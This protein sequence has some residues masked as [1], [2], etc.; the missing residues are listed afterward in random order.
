MKGEAVSLKDDYLVADIRNEF[1]TGTMQEKLA[2]LPFT[3]RE[4]TE[5][6]GVNKA[7][8][9]RWKNCLMT[10]S[11]ESALRLAELLGLRA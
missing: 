3:D 10:P 5:L 2:A 11:P 9:W 8:L 6:L 4:K 7:T 1:R